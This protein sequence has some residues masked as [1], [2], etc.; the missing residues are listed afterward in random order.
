LVAISCLRGESPFFR[1]L[2]PFGM[3]KFS[4]AICEPL[5]PFRAFGLSGFAHLRGMRL[6]EVGGVL[7]K[8]GCPTVGFGCTLVM[9]HAPLRV[10]GQSRVWCV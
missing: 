8:I 7:V 4:L 1:C 9:P 6:M 5:R 3:G 2:Q 10:K